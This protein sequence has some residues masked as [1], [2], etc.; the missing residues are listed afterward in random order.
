MSEL[1]CTIGSRLRDERSRLGLSQ[2]ALGEIVGASKRTVIDWEKGATSPTSAQ[3]ADLA[4]IGLDPLYVLVGQ[5][6][7]ARAG[8]AQEQIAMFNE[9]IDTF[10]ALSDDS[11]AIALTML[12]G[13]LRKDVQAE[14]S[15]SVRKRTPN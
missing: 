12:G 5:R 3:L 6:S 8:L 1:I 2:T 4:E 7:V 13:L 10:W 14:A 15:R 9:V 11:R